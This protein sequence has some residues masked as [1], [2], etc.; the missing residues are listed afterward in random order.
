MQESIL[1]YDLC[2]TMHRVVGGWLKCVIFDTLL[3][4]DIYGGL[5]I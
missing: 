3:W 1:G 5:D 4:R 2:G